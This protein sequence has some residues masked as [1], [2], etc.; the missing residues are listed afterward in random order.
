MDKYKHAPRTHCRCIRAAPLQLPDSNADT[1]AIA[2]QLVKGSQQEQRSGL[3][4][5]LLCA[6]KQNPLYGEGASGP[7]SNC[8]GHRGS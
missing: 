2:R 1:V 5:E 3:H 8:R 6:E 4:W 7:A